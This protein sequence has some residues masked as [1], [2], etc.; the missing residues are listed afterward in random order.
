MSINII[1][2]VVE[3]IIKMAL[4]DNYFSIQLDVNTQRLQTNIY[5]GWM[6][7]SVDYD[8]L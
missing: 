2:L 6:T 4:Y 7:S 1:L 8:L 3:S 5:E